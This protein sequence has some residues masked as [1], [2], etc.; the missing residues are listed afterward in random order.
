MDVRVHQDIILNTSTLLDAREAVV[1]LPAMTRYEQPGGGT[2]TST[3]RM[4]YF[5]P[6]I[7]GPRIGEARAE[8]DIYVDLARRVKPEAAAA[9]GLRQ[10]RS[11][12]RGDR[13][14]RAEL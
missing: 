10:R 5:S 14:G 2:S 4:V 3:E 9:A 6:E 11:D 8:W 13:A 7:A 1:V 12:P